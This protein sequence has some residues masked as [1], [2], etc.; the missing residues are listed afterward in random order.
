MNNVITGKGLTTEEVYKGE[1]LLNEKKLLVINSFESAEQIVSNY[2]QNAAQKFVVGFAKD[3]Q[4]H[5]L[6]IRYQDGLHGL[7]GLSN[8][9]KGTY[10]KEIYEY[11]GDLYVL[12][13]L[14]SIETQFAIIADMVDYFEPSSSA[15]GTRYVLNFP[16]KWIIQES[17]PAAE[18]KKYIEILSSPRR[19]KY[20]QWWVFVGS[21]FYP[22]Y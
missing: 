7:A 18:A 1:S 14:Q 20:S 16:N 4:K 5:V 21:G 2:T 12:Y 11:E 10:T 9:E 15:Y 3:I 22:K 17:F 6:C 8:I 13:I 19:G